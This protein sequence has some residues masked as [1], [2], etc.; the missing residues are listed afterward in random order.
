M[1]IALYGHKQKR[2]SG[3]H[4]SFPGNYE[5]CAAEPLHKRNV[6][7]HG[8]MLTKVGLVDVEFGDKH[9]LELRA[10]FFSAFNVEEVNKFQLQYT[11]IGNAAVD[12]YLEAV[13]KEQMP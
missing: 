4:G 9:R 11:R 1:L 2:F 7:S 3:W 12:Q 10:E 5:S 8:N 13:Q 6:Q